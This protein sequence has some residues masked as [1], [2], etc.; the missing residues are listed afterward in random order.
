[1]PAARSFLGRPGGE[2]FTDLGKEAVATAELRAAEL[3]A[4]ADFLKQRAETLKG[5]LNDLNAR[6]PTL[7][8]GTYPVFMLDIDKLLA[9]MEA[10]FWAS[11]KE[12][13]LKVLAGGRE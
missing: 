3:E 7:N 1:M 13:L 6:A 10:A 9:D 4:M 11:R 2:S 8:A 5:R 12:A